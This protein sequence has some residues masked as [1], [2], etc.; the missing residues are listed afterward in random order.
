M[1][2][3]TKED[4]IKYIN[5]GTDLSTADVSAITDMSEIFKDVTFSQDISNWDVSNVTNMK[6]MFLNSIFDEDISN[7]DVSNVTNMKGMFLNSKF[8]RDISK[9]NVSNVTNVS[10]MF[11]NSSFNSDISNWNVSN[12]LYANEMFKDSIFNQN[13]SNWNTVSMFNIER[14]FQN[15]VFDYDING[16]NVTN[17]R[18]ANLAF[19]NAKYSYGINGWDLN[20]NCDIYY[21][22]GYI[23]SKEKLS[24]RLK[25]V[26]GDKISFLKS[27]SDYDL[28]TSYLED[29]VIRYK[30]DNYLCLLKK[31][32]YKG[33]NISL[34]ISSDM[35]NKLKTSTYFTKFIKEDD[36]YYY[37]EWISGVQASDINIQSTITK[38]KNDFPKSLYID[39][40]YLYNINDFIDT[41]NGTICVDVNALFKVT[42]N[43]IT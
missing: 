13:I 25:V 14:M 11:E 36:N 9:W 24:T 15:S 16:W 27:L 20:N 29:S 41:E 23:G 28:V 5:D 2:V 3:S 32:T 33:N 26:Y 18:R 22:F 8:N 4:L 30:N 7:W 43:T 10:S 17:I 42:Y 6:G 40:D 19:N 38:I 39:S 34:N 31:Y 21:I 12:V 35:L 1:T 37:F